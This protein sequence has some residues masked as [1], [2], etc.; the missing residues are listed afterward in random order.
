ML[1]NLDAPLSCFFPWPNREMSFWVKNK[2]EDT[3]LEKKNGAN[4]ISFKM[5]QNSMK[6]R[7]ICSK[8]KAALTRENQGKCL[9]G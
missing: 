4:S 8:N 2:E 7:R 5:E 3:K 9:Q 1:Q 6:T